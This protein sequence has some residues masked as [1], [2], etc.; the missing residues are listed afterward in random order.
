[1]ESESSQAAKLFLEGPDS[2][3]QVGLTAEDLVRELLEAAKL[4][5][6][7]IHK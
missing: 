7:P 4:G 1:M 6:D 3:F 5:D 2:F